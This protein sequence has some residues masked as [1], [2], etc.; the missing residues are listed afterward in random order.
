MKQKWKAGWR[1]FT[2]GIRRISAFFDRHYLARTFGYILVSV[3]AVG[4]I[5]YVGY[6]M[7][8]ELQPGLELVDAVTRTV[9]TTVEAD[10]YIMRSERPVY[11]AYTTAGS[12]TA[13]VADG[14][15]T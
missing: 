13:S 7:V 4:L 10:A 5:F 11:A 1:R 3:L 14:G 6:H 9:T 15:N 8:D 2:V 12:V